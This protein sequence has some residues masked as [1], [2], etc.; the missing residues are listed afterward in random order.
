[1]FVKKIMMSL[2]LLLGCQNFFLTTNCVKVQT[3]NVS[4]QITTNHEYLLRKDVVGEVYNAMNKQT[5]PKVHLNAIDVTSKDP[6]YVAFRAL[7]EKKAIN[8]A[9]RLYPQEYVT[10]AQLAKIIANSFEIAVDQRNKIKFKDVQENH[11]AKH[12]IESLADAGII[13]GT[14]KGMYS[15]NSKVTKGQLLEIIKRAKHLK[16]QEANLTIVYDYLDQ[17]YIKTNI[18]FPKQISEVIQLVNQERK[19]LGIQPLRQDP[20][21]NQLAVIKIQDMFE[22]NY[23]DHYSKHY[24]YPWDMAT[25][26]NYEFSSFGE[27]I[28]RYSSSPTTVVEAWMASDSHKQNM[29]KKNYT[30]TGVGIKKNSQGKYY[31]VQLFSSK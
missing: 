10:R 21:L 23:F 28:A 7:V 22:Y 13:V 26:F 5:N 11:W 17:R 1:M 30:H 19:K 14:G 31:W 12:Y 9:E 4:A 27:N 6:S 2:I 15:P 25:I 3:N 24:G 20:Y 16:Q 18:D 29:L 8:N